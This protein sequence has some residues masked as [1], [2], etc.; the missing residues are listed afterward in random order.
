MFENASLEERARDLVRK[1][2]NFQVPRC[3]ADRGNSRSR[4]L[5]VRLY[6]CSCSSSTGSNDTAFD[7]HSG[8][9]MSKKT[10]KPSLK[11]VNEGD[12]DDRS[13]Q[14]SP[15]LEIEWL[16][17]YVKAPWES[18]TSYPVRMTAMAMKLDQQPG[19]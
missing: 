4:I 14:L 7:E 19:G 11:H 5:A 9:K 15:S 17:R 1:D 16:S 12:P 10:S 3:C 8:R 6:T 13:W 18:Q 2:A